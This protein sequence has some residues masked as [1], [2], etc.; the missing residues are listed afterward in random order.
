VVKFD[1][2]NHTVTLKHTQGNETFECRQ[3]CEILKE[4]ENKSVHQTLIIWDQVPSKEKTKLAKR[5]NSFYLNTSRA[6]AFHLCELYES[7]PQTLKGCEGEGCG[8]L[9]YDKVTKTVDVR[10]RP[11]KS[12]EII[13]VLKR[14]SK[15]KGFKPYTVLKELGWARV[16]K[17]NKKLDELGV[18]SGSLI[19]VAKSLGEGYLKVCAGRSE[20]DAVDLGAT[21]H[22]DVAVVETLLNHRAEGWIQLALES[23]GRGFV[24]E[25]EDFYQGYYSY[26]PSHFCPEDHPCGKAFNRDLIATEGR[27]GEL[28]Y[29]KCRQIPACSENGKGRAC[30]IGQK[31]WKR[32]QD[33]LPKQA[34]FDDFSVPKSACSN[35]WSG[36]LSG[37][38]QKESERIQIYY[39]YNCKRDGDKIGC[40]YNVSR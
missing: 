31:V 34:A 26:E 14:C 27:L 10:K 11:D 9:K 22:G 39:S 5:V 37:S 24:A 30:S 33:Y 21:P 28:F 6:K 1:E 19:Q 2:V 18:S 8:I 32:Y 3:S 7:L 15:L 25:R 13:G 40:Q 17:S 4:I 29:E 16:V 38:C 36:T 20:V 23:N 35:L 12:S